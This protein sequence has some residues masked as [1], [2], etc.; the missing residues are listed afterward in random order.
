MI[1]CNNYQMNF[2]ILNGKEI[3][4]YVL[5]IARLRI[6]VFKEFLTVRLNLCFVNFRMFIRPDKKVALVD[7]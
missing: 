4:A 2:K 6:E 5:D 3:E 7:K 1:L